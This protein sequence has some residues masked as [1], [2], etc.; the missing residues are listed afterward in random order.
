MTWVFIVALAKASMRLERAV[1]V[2]RL[3][4]HQADVAIRAAILIQARVRGRVVR[5]FRAKMAVLRP[6]LVHL[7]FR[8]RLRRCIERKRS[9][10]RAITRFIS[11]VVS[12][13]DPDAARV[14]RGAAPASVAECASLLP[15]SSFLPP[16]QVALHRYIKTFM[17]A[18]HKVQR[19][20]RNFLAC[21]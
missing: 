3:L 12:P 16:P 1:A 20:V 10:A 15:P 18:V 8:W 6:L 17:G 13:N 9:A 4:R 19:T 21:R 2:D 7:V 5:R 14:R 11:D